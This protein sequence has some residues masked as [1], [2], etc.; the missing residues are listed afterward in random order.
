MA[1]TAIDSND[2]LLAL[3]EPDTF[4]DQARV[5]EIFTRLR[6]D[7]P[8]AWT[9]EPFGGPGF[10]S[11]TRYDDIQFVSKNPALSKSSLAAATS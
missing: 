1:Q 4:Q 11:V 10:W 7:D 6:R 9:P 2:E 8:V 5:H 3:S